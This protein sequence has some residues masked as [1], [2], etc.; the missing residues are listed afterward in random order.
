MKITQE[1]NKAIKK[2]KKSLLQAMVGLMDLKK[3]TKSDRANLLESQN[4]QKQKSTRIN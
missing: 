3:D 4:I 1:V 2:Y